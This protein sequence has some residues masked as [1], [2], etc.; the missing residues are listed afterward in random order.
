MCAVM[1]GFASAQ[2][3]PPAPTTLIRPSVK[4]VRI[5]VSEAPII[6]GDLSDPVWAKAGVIDKFTQK[7]PNP[8]E[9]GTERTVLRILYDQ[10]NLYFSFYAYDSH[11]DQIIPGSMERD[12]R[13]AA[14]DSVRLLS[15]V[16]P[17]RVVT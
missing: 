8:G 17:P 14:A 1:S 9:P 11:P 5:D 13:L 10:N 2:P 3:A 12:G 15:A 7:A 4:A 6:D 16:A